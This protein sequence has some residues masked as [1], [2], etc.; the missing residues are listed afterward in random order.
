MAEQFINQ[1]NTSTQWKTVCLTTDPKIIV[2]NAE[3]QEIIKELELTGITGG[4][5]ILSDIA[6]SADDVLL[7]CNKITDASATTMFKVYKWENDDAAPTVLFTTQ[8]QANTTNAEIGETF[9]VAGAISNLYIYYT[10]KSGANYRIV[11]LNYKNETK[12]VTDKYMGADTNYPVSIWGEHVKFTISPSG[13]D[14]IIVDSDVMH[15]TEYKF[16]WSAVDGAA[17]LKKVN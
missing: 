9:T 8:K 10:V 16:D 6:F 4:S 11:G 7:A 1:T 14:H 15:T 5:S 12:S 17:L 2:I 13:Y 3:T